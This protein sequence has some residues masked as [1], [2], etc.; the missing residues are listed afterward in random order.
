MPDL[1]PTPQALAIH[2]A[3]LSPEQKRFNS[4]V[5]RLDAARALLAAWQGAIAQF[6]ADYLRQHLPLL[7]TARATRRRW[8]LALDAAASAERLGRADQDAVG[9][10]IGEA[11]DELLDGGADAEV[12]AV[13]DR[14]AEVDHDTL[15]AERLRALKRLTEQA[16]GLDL[17]PDDEL[18]DEDDLRQRTRA[19]MAA[20]AEAE[21]EADTPTGAPAARPRRPPAAQRRQEAEALAA[22]LS[23][24]E[25]FRKLA[26]ALHPDREPDPA[27]RAAKTALMQQANQAH[28]AND[29]LSLLGLQLRLEQIDASH[30]AHADAARLK[31][32]N[33]VLDGQLA[34]LRRETAAVVDDFTAEFGLDPDDAA[35]PR[36]LRPAL[37]AEVARTR[38]WIAELERQIRRF[39][40]PVETRRWLRSARKQLREGDASFDAPLDDRFR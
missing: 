12:R 19:A 36:R 15:R 25:V 11:C 10:L 13:H 14:W 8:V 34:E 39:G 4:L 5:A 28:A 16:T 3:S 38:H 29:L 1:Q 2:G 20:A 26:S 7:A 17:G 32:Y 21:A 27:R 40:D 24:R 6:R 30:L 37:A 22:T 33:K 35:S 18:T 23:V 9:R 31:R